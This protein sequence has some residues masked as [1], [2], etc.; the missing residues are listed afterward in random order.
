MSRGADT[1]PSVTVTRSAW[2]P[3]VIVIVVLALIA[4]ALYWV[5]FRQ[6]SP[7]PGW[8]KV[9][10]VADVQQ[11]RVTKVDNSA[12]VVSYGGLPLY[13]FAASYIDGLHEKVYYCPASGWFFNEPHATAYDIV[14]RYK[15][16]PEPSSTLPR[17]AVTVVD[18]DV[19]V[20]PAQPVGGL[21]A[22][23]D[24]IQQPA[25]GPFCQDPQQAL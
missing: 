16:G 6:T 7:G 25:D 9:G 15:L 21:V 1:V 4:I 3:L 2:R 19:W 24:A 12:Y 5:G 23:A 20:D 18:E 17:V 10:S 8:V 22:G 11:Q 13:A 14:G